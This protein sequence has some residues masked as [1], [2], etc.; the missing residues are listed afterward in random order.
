MAFG[1]VASFLAGDLQA[2]DEGRPVIELF[3]PRDYQGHNQMWTA[4][5]SKA[6]LLYFGNRGGVFEFDSANWRKLPIP[7]SFVRSI[8]FGPDD[9]L[10]ASGTDE[11]GRF[12][13]DQ[14]GQLVYESLNSYVP[15]ELKPLGAGWSIAV[16]DDAVFFSFAQ[17]ILKWNGQ[18]M[19]SW[20]EPRTEK[21]L[22][23]SVGQQLY[24]HR[25]GL[26]LYR[27]DG[28]QFS[29]VSQE[30]IWA[31]ARLPILLPDESSDALVALD[32]GGL[33]HLHGSILKPSVVA[34][35]KLLNQSGIGQGQRLANGNIAIATDKLGIVILD[36]EGNPLRQIDE[37]EGMGSDRIFGLFEDRQTNLWAMTQNGLAR[38]EHASPYTLF[39]RTN[40]LGRDFVRTFCRHDGVLYAATASGLYHLIPGDLTKGTSARF[41][42]NEL[43]KSNVWSLA[44]HPSGLLVG[45]A[46]ELLLLPKTNSAPQTLYT[47]VNPIIS[48]YV[49]EHITRF[50]YVGLGTGFIILEYADNQWQVRNRIEELSAD[51]RSIA[52]DKNGV[53]WLGTTTRG[54]FKLSQPAGVH[55]W[56]NYT[57]TQYLGSN[58]LPNDQGWSMVWNGPNGLLFSTQNGIYRYED[59]DDIFIRES[60]FRRDG[61]DCKYV[62]PLIT[63]HEGLVWAQTEMPGGDDSLRIGKYLPENGNFKWQ[64]QPAK[65]SGL[66]GYG[67]S[68]S[69]YWEST[70][71]GDAVWLSGAEHTVRVADNRRVISST[72]KPPVIRSIGHPSSK[73]HPTELLQTS[74][75]TFTFSKEP[76]LIEYIA[77]QFDPTAKIEY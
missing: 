71:D 18:T 65:L 20:I 1:F 51:V 21:Q 42:K 77:A 61:H 40:G 49:S 72:I 38:I 55:D 11:L 68:R 5:Q 25:P 57:L 66:V 27:F 37:S 67:G 36:Q 59:S 14:N 28:A 8:I 9:L 19:E 53:F 75:P 31:N 23:H 52:E 73:L 69:M 35:S 4:A 26:G 74:S 3:T 56:A 76:V 48:L 58:G 60:A 41:E 22:L 47:H 39:D 63:T 30:P 33:Y 16:H 17:T 10:Y 34:G 29:I 24:L 13:P 45:T 62:Q 32:Q 44:S 50:A 46:R 64:S 70:P 54:I 2:Y 43:V 7:T 6:G 15:E 12:K